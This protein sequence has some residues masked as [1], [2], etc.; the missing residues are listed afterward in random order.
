M[1]IAKE[2]GAMVTDFS[3]APFTIDKQEILAT[4]GKIHREMV[5]LLD[6]NAPS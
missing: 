5:S 4:N 2:A 3:E 1:L 6:V